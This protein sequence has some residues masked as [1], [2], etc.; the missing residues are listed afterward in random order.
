LF[1]KNIE[2]LV[3]GLVSVS[4]YVSVSVSV[5]SYLEDTAHM[6]QP[7]A[8]FNYRDML[9][10]SLSLSLVSLVRERVACNIAMQLNNK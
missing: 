9:S 10:L 8:P 2:R 7:T 3:F 6:H 5:L 1:G 4:V